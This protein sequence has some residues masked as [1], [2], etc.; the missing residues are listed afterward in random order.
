MAD[1]EA[2]KADGV[3]T[4][5]PIQALGGTA[6]KPVGWD[7]TGWESFK[8]MLYDHEKGEILT[9][10]PLS[11]LKIIV[12]YCIYYSCLAGFWIGC[13]HIFF[14]TL[15]EVDD[16]PR[17]KWDKSLI[18]ENPGV[19]L[20][21]RNNDKDIDSQMFVLKYNDVNKFPSE[22]LGEGIQNADYATRTKEFLETYNNT[23]MYKKKYAT[24]NPKEDL[25]NGDETCGEYPY[26]YVATKDDKGVIT[27]PVSP[28]IYVKLNNIW[29]F[30]PKPIA[31]DHKD[32]PKSLKDHWQSGDGQSP[33][34]TES[35]W[36]D[37]LGRYASDQEALADWADGT[38]SMTYFPKE[39]N[40][41]LRFFPYL[42]K[43]KNAAGKIVKTYH[44][45][46]VAI[47]INLQP[48]FI[49]Q[50]IHIEC[51]AYYDG[52]KHITKSKE[53]LVQFEVQ[54]KKGPLDED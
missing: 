9:R 32:V 6:I 47:K 5:Q 8:Y 11:W 43:E 54:I 44:N 28:C 3:P 29:D 17:W 51:R 45:P 36:I 19:G 39:R 13:L 18:G 50:L 46:L 49:G 41:P 42:G 4:E 7:R 10:T 48:K 2:R 15:P 21:P 40:L 20:R 34:L 30:T 25:K 26:G 38:K 14:A 27:S 52:V 22:L 33:S 31:R 16:G 12:F 24:F 53:G 37:C 23:H 35:V 1:D